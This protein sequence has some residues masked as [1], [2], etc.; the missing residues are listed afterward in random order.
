MNLFILPGNPPAL[1]FYELWAQEIR[2]QH[3]ESKIEIAHYPL[4]Q[5]EGDSH[6]YF[7]DLVAVVTKQF[8]EFRKREGI[9]ASLVGHSL[10]GYL[11]LK[12]LE[13]VPSEVEKC[14]LLHPFLRQ[15]LK[16]GRALLKLAYELRCHTPMEK[17]LVRLQPLVSLALEEA[18]KITAEEIHVFTQLAYHE[19]LTI[20]QDQSSP[21]VAPELLKKVFVYSTE[22]DIWCPPATVASL[23][24]DVRHT[25]GSASHNFVVTRKNRDRVS[26]YLSTAQ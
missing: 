25:V 10:G 3:P 1:H 7:R 11:A 17:W 9:Q 16:R 21:A 24:K 15:P 2:A 26:A 12:I 19:H 5:S 13:K 6:A 4:W 14:Y 22:G 23:G 20:S 18:S 8:L